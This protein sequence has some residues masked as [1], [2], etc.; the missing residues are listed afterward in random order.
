M[1]CRAGPIQQRSVWLFWVTALRSTAGALQRF[2]NTRA[3]QT[4]PCLRPNRRA[5]DCALYC[6]A[7]PQ[8][9]KTTMM[10][11]ETPPRLIETKTFS[12]M[13]D[14]FRRKGVR[15]DWAD[16]NRPGVPT[17]SFIEGPSFDK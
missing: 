10:Y 6:R 1:R 17:D 8:H 11:L 5:G 2:R 9:T 15:T 13:P 3:T 12:A 4:Q 14:R 16:A 7:S